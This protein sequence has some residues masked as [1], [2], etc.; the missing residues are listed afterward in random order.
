MAAKRTAVFLI[1]NEV[2]PRLDK[3]EGTVK[4]AGLNG[5]TADLRAFLDQRAVDAANRKKWISRAKVIGAVLG[6]TWA[7]AGTILGFQQILNAL[8]HH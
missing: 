5:H 7:L 2:I 6:A 4:E 8:Q 1:E 3:L